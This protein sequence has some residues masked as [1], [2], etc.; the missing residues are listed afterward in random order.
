MLD[1]LAPNGHAALRSCPLRLPQDLQ[2][3]DRGELHQLRLEPLQQLVKRRAVDR[4]L[5]EFTGEADGC[6][7]RVSEG[8]YFL[9]E[10]GSLRSFA[11]PA[12][13]TGRGDVLRAARIDFDRFGTAEAPVSV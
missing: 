1:G 8:G 10:G 6:Q 11:A 5:V 7:L 12:P 13:L 2:V 9:G 3:N 4:L